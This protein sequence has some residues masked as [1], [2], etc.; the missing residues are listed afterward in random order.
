MCVCVCVCVCVLIA[1]QAG[2]DNYL[3]QCSL[4]I[5]IINV[6]STVFSSDTDTPA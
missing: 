3:L 6:V 1:I 5:I 2:V 4:T